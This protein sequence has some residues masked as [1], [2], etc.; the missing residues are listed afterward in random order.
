MLKYFWDLTME[1]FWEQNDVIFW[2]YFGVLAINML[3][4]KKWSVFTKALPT[5]TTFFL[6][7]VYASVKPY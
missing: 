1:Y 7:T 2:K 6:D 4:H 5:W 3:L